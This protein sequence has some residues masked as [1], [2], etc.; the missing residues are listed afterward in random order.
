MRIRRFLCVVLLVCAS[1]PALAQPTDAVKAGF[2]ALEQN[3]A[4]R[5][6]AIFDEALSHHPHDAVLLYGAGVAA[7][8]Q[9]RERDA[10]AF[11]TKAFDVEPRF[12]QAA[13][14]L[15]SI[16]YHDGDLDLAIKTYERAL[17]QAPANLSIRSQLEAWRREAALPQNRE[18]LKDDRFAI[19]FDGPAQEQL[20]LRATTVLREAFWRIGQTLGSYP[21]SPITVILYTQRQFRSVTGAPEWAGG[22]FDGQIRMPVRGA[23]QNLAEF[24]RILAHELTHAMLKQIAAR[25]VPAWLNEGLAMYFEGH[26]AERAGRR[27]AAARLFVPLEALSTGF[28]RLDGGQAAVAYEESAF[29]V[30]ALLD[31]IGPTALPALLQALDGGQTIEEAVQRFGFTLEDFERSLAVR[32]GAAPRAAAPLIGFAPAPRQST[33]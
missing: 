17:A 19:M 7:H 18:S 14:L 8:L 23:T 29:T 31:R 3:D 26:D 30:A 20:A 32:V 11:L 16:A 28:G 1:A 24:D 15:G 10:S 12:V 9:G 22:G 13:V 25:N 4:D 6:R 27:L 2:A 21:S 33:I 5:A